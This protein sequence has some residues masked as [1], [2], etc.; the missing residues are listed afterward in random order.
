MRADGRRA[1]EAAR[2]AGPPRSRHPRD[3]GRLRRRGGHGRRLLRRRRGDLAAALVGRASAATVRRAA[4]VPDRARLPRAADG[5]QQRGDAGRGT[6]DRSP[7][8]APRTPGSGRAAETGHPVVCLNER[9]ARPGAYEV[10]LGTPLRDIVEELGGGLAGRQP[11]AGAAGRR[12][13]RR[14]P[15]RRTTWICRCST[16][17]SRRPERRSATAAWSASTSECRSRRAA[18]PRCGSFGAAGELRHLHAVPRGHP[19]RGRDP[20]RTQRGRRHCSTLMECRPACAPSAAGY[21]AAVR[22]LM[23][24]YGAAHES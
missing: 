5:G 8:A 21:P 20:V 18:Q 12:S 1:V 3:R 17:R 24:V 16:P 19:P 7:T 9:F 14:L 13:P 15:R 6:G 22:S 4:A 23:R 11:A 2:S 10:E